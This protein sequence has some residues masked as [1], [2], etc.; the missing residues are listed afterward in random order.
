MMTTMVALMAVASAMCAQAISPVYKTT[1]ALALAPKSC[2]SEP[3]KRVLVEFL[4]RPVRLFA[5]R[6]Y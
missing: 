2:V 6:N 1:P 4:I 5:F 3:Q